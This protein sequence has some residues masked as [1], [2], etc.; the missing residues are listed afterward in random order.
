M[1]DGNVGISF[2]FNALMLL[3]FIAG[4]VYHILVFNII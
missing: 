3:T 2:S 1:L 4:R